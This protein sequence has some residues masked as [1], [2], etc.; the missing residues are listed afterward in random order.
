MMR[1]FEK[2]NIKILR[3]QKSLIIKGLNL[4][5][6]DNNENARDASH[7]YRR[8]ADT[9]K[10]LYKE[11]GY[12]STDDLVNKTKALA[13]ARCVSNSHSN[14]TYSLYFNFY[15]RQNSSLTLTVPTM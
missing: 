6:L 10:K 13:V 3:T 11:E 12:N 1:Y 9:L 4:L 2:H 14:D 7:Y 5:H 15:Q 8:N